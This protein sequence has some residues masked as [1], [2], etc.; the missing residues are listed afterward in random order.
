MIEPTQKFLQQRK[1]LMVLPLI[2]L[3]FLA[4][5]FW[6]LGGGTS[7][8]DTV[9]TKTGLNTQLPDA[10]LKSQSSLDKLSFY[11]MADRDSVKRLEQERM[12]PNYQLKS[13]EN[14]QSTDGSDEIWNRK[15]DRQQKQSELSE[16]YEKRGKRP[17][18]ESSAEIDRLQ[19]MMQSLDQRKTDPEIEALNGTLEKLIELQNP[20][21][22]KKQIIIDQKGKAFAVTAGSVDAD[23]SY[24]GGGAAKVGNGFFSDAGEER[25]SARRGLIA[26]MVH[27]EQTLTGGSVIKLRLLQDVFVKG[28]K[29]PVG[30]FLFGHAS[31]DNE[32]LKVII[33]SIQF[34][35]HLYPVEL[36]VYDMDGIEG[37][38]IPGSLS[39]DVVK[40]ST[41]QGIQSVG[42]F[43]F[44]PSLRAQ[45]AAAGVNAVKSL[46]SKKVKLVRVIVKAGY[47]VLLKDENQKSN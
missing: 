5:V 41:D 26:A 45:A 44:D 36:T 24:F 21:K 15:I 6:L 47:K 23:T 2:V 38:S 40:Q 3:P 14:I 7:E 12:D 19:M 37:I 30:S 13:S 25:D 29:I 31:I 9:S 4:L 43:S 33:S 39:R 17:V 16:Y 8:K 28:E 42:G 11:A 32:R 1:F 10:N 46:L 18:L 22:A 35:N 27:G 34:Q 20:L